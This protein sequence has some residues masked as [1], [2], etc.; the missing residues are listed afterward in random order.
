MNHGIWRK[1]DKLDDTV[2]KNLEQKVHHIFMRYGN[3]RD[4][5]LTHASEYEKDILFKYYFPKAKE[6]FLEL[7]PCFGPAVFQIFFEHEIYV[8]YYYSWLEGVYR[9]DDDATRVELSLDFMYERVVHSE[10]LR[11]FWSEV[12]PDADRGGVSQDTRDRMDAMKR[13]H[14]ALKN[15]AF[16]VA[17]KKLKEDVAYETETIRLEAQWRQEEE[18]AKQKVT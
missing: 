4:Q 15:S 12:D 16:L 11:Q 2:E 8:Q 5:V 6:R 1:V 9:N 7:L 13:L 18:E 17:V 14:D 3:D 10:L